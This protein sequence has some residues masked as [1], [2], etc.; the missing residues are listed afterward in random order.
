VN[1]TNDDDAVL[2]GAPTTAVVVGFVLTMDSVLGA[3]VDFGVSGEVDE[4]IVVVMYI[5]FDAVAEGP[6]LVT[7][8][9]ATELEPV[10][11]ELEPVAMELEPVATELEPVAT[12]LE[13][14]AMELEPVAMELELVAMELDKSVVELDKA[15]V[16][17]E[18]AVVETD[19]SVVVVEETMVELGGAVLEL[20]EIT[21]LVQLVETK[22]ATPSANAALKGAANEAARA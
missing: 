20:E 13:P 14:V 5:T 19:K 3:P 8:P 16:V 9:V 15:V 17:V 7:E 11:M 2:V 6:V 22:A 10:A 18:E 12:E 21:A 1:N 4:Q